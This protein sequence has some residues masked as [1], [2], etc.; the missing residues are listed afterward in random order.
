MSKTVG[1]K[2]LKAALLALAAEEA[3]Q[4]HEHRGRFESLIERIRERLAE[5]TDATE[6]VTSGV[7][8]DFSTVIHLAKR[9]LRMKKDDFEAAVSVLNTPVSRVVDCCPSGKDT[10]DVPDWMRMTAEEMRMSYDLM[11]PYEAT[12]WISDHG[13]QWGY[14]AAAIATARLE[15]KVLNGERLTKLALEAQARTEAERAQLD[16]WMR[17]DY[18]ERQAAEA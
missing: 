14:G 9:V 6:V 17:Q 12:G 11:T 8:D 10:R 1:K 2:T 5:M 7:R 4:E 3:A 16:A 15:H 13:A 18:L